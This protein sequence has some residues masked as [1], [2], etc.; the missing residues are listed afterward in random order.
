MLSLWALSPV[1]SFEL[2]IGDLLPPR[3]NAS[4]DSP[5]DFNQITINAVQ[6]LL[7]AD[8]PSMRLKVSS[9]L[10]PQ[11]LKVKLVQRPMRQTTLDRNTTAKNNPSL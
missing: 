6:A 11:I 1:N 7:S 5:I 3:T 10:G 9:S 8:A 4:L 2:K